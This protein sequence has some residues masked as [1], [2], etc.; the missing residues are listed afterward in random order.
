MAVKALVWPAPRVGAMTIPSP[1]A[2][3]W[4]PLALGFRP[5]FLLAGLAAV[6]LLG[7]WLALAVGNLPHPAHYDAVG[8]HSHDPVSGNAQ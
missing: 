1:S 4:A 8:W 7:G 2:P 5:F 6:A 3:P